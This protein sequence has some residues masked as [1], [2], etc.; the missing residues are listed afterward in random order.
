MVPGKAQNLPL[1]QWQD[2]LS[3][4]QGLAVCEGGGNVYCCTS[5]GVFT[6]NLSDN[7]LQ[8]YSKVSGL[9]DIGCTVAR[10]NTFTNT[11]VIGYSNGNIDLLNNN[12]IIN[13]PDLKNSPA[14]GAKTINNI[15]FN[16]NLAYVSCGQGIMVI[17]LT[18]NIILSLYKIGNRGTA[19]NV[20][21]ITIF[22]DTIFA[23]TENGIYKTAASDPDPQN[24][25][26]WKIVSHPA[27][28]G[29]YNAIVSCGNKMYA[30]FSMRLTGN[31]LAAFKQ[32]TLYVYNSGKWSL[33]TITHNGHHDT[34]GI[35]ENMLS[36]Q[37]ITFNDTSYLTYCGASNVVVLD[38]FG[39]T[40][41][42][43]FSYNF[44]NN[45]NA[46]DAVFDNTKHLWM[47][48]PN[49]GLVKA[50][51]SFDGENF[52][53]S[54]PFSNSAFAM[55]IQGSTIYL[56][57]GAYDN[58]YAPESITNIGISEYFD[59]FWYRLIDDASPDTIQNLCCV[60]ID[61]KNSAHAFAGSWNN[62]LVEYYN[63][64][65]VNFFNGSNS[66]LRSL[67][68]A[69]IPTYYSLRV[70]GVA[71][72]SSENLWATNSG[73]DSKY[74]S[75][76]QRNGT[77]QSMDFSDIPN[78]PI[79]GIVTTLIVTH[80]GAK[81]MIFPGNGILAYQDNGTFAQPTPSNSVFINGSVNNGHLPSPNIYCITE[82]QNGAIWVGTDL[83]VVV[84]YSPDNVFNGP[85]GWDA[86]NIYVQQTGYTQY[87]MQNQ[88][89]TAIAVDGANRKWIGTLG[90]GV[91]LMSA[92]GTQQILNFTSANSPLPSN[93]IL[94][95]GINQITGDVFLG[96]DQGV[97]SYRGEA[98][99]GATGFSNLYA[100]PDPVPHGYSGPI[101]INNLVANSDIKIATVSGEVVYHTVA[102]GG[103]A[104]WNGTN[105]SGERVQTGV[106]LVFC[107]SPDGTQSAVTKL[108]F[109]N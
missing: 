7:S 69:Q 23:A 24:Y 20:Y 107:T 85:G 89:T 3:Y 9:S 78:I 27:P 96:T 75:V 50:S 61:P 21:S 67:I 8:R 59:N 11:L 19:L 36:L 53:P 95:I 49:Y 10:Y 62:G 100:Y 51:N 101:A 37:S 5:S 25:Q 76:K 57:P 40:A 104:I 65:I 87:L 6:Y 93:N 2:F 60:A 74:L 35:H 109:V 94:S 72:D 22:N 63:D 16:N 70:G 54:G 41:V 14:E 46:V 12:Q 48:D 64:S 90:G 102:L 98:S 83:Q 56:A 15:Y 106:Y 55:A 71:F 4:R 38:N 86:Q 91:F 32:D 105:F 68:D 103:R 77:W 73:V 88:F 33:D 79:D 31:N 29:V 42:H 82:D 34:D 28:V 39:D 97:V 80:S 108:L 26:D 30:S 58:S 45:V 44:S 18:Q 47:A 52:Y 17:D 99:L 66:S 81:W 13:L 43:L 1:G 92:D 84:F